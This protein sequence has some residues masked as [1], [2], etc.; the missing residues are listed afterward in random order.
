[1]HCWMDDGWMDVRFGENKRG[2]KKEKLVEEEED[3][4]E[5]GE[6]QNGE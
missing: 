6:K 4:G 3:P 1:M 5:Y 2:N